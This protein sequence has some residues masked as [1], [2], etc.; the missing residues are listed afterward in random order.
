MDRHLGKRD[1]ALADVND[2]EA[3]LAPCQGRSAG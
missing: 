2:I 1:W 3:F